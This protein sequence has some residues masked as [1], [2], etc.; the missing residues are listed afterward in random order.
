MRVLYIAPDSEIDIY[1]NNIMYFPCFPPESGVSHHW[2]L[3]FLV[4]NPPKNI[5][6][7]VASFSAHSRRCAC[8]LSRHNHEQPHIEAISQYSLR[9]F[10][11]RCCSR[12]LFFWLCFIFFR[13]EEASWSWLSPGRRW[14]QSGVPSHRNNVNYLNNAVFVTFFATI[15]ADTGWPRVPRPNKFFSFG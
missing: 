8:S 13:E 2:I 14:V 4:F 9:R 11:T 7:G 10:H 3:D 15:W 1:R 5:Y 6:R 12:D